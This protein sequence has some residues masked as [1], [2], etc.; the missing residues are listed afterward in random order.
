MSLDV[1]VVPDGNTM[2]EI[3]DSYTK[4]IS[5]ATESTN[6]LVQ[7]SAEDREARV[8]RYREKRKNQKFEKTIIHF[9]KIL[10]NEAEVSFE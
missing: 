1:G 8:L 2:I 6:Q 9:T 10:C 4:P 7:I 3:F 5:A